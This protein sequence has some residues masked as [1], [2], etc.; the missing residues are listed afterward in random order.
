VVMGMNSISFGVHLPGNVCYDEVKGFA[1]EAEELGYDS[2]WYAD[3]LYVR[4]RDRILECWTTLAS[5]AAVTKRIRLGPLVTCNLFRY[6][7]LLA[8]MATTVDLISKGR[9]EV[10]IG[11][12]WHKGEC[13]AYGVPFPEPKIRQAQFME[14]L[15]VLRKMWTEEHASY[16][17]KY[18]TL[19]EAECWPKPVQKLHPPITIGGTGEIL[20]PK[21]AAK[22]ANRYNP[23]PW[24]CTLE[25][26]RQHLAILKGKCL[27]TG[28][29]Y[30]D[31]EKA[32]FG[33]V[34]VSKD[35]KELEKYREMKR[36]LLDSSIIG[37]PSECV[38]KIQEYV[39]TG[40]NY[41]IAYFG[42]NISSMKLFAQEVRPEINQAYI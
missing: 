15:E 36:K 8:K 34:I 4:D 22:Y 11:M 13:E 9:L 26:A 30:E 38:E 35:E 12:G 23:H 33:W 39:E 6:P 7:S 25:R 16:E 41:F 17:G 42:Q 5:L 32:W 40:M 1:L 14:A 10:G 37:T 19:R 21:L 20:T 24:T 2:L 31:I 29:K 28:R 3:H 18:Y 27:E